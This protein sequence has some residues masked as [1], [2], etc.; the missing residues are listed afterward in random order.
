MRKCYS[1][2]TDRESLRRHSASIVSHGTLGIEVCIFHKCVRGI[3]FD[4]PLKAFGLPPAPD[5]SVSHTGCDFY[6]VRFFSD[7]CA[8]DP[9]LRCP[10]SMSTQVNLATRRD[11]AGV[12]RANSRMSSGLSNPESALPVVCGWRSSQYLARGELAN[13]FP[14]SGNGPTPISR[15]SLE[16][17]S[18]DF[19]H[20]RHDSFSRSHPYGDC[21]AMHQS[22]TRVDPHQP[23]ISEMDNALRLESR[24]RNGHANA[25]SNSHRAG[26]YRMQ[27][28]QP[29]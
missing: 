28:I 7:A 18:R 6:Q 3:V 20:E 8:E 21:S 2:I 17:L 16:I 15:R 22:I 12:A 13:N 27:M 24:R 25:N 10:D 5:L 4:L 11:S 9:V 14:Q 26:L 29:P 1:L 23:G 19:T